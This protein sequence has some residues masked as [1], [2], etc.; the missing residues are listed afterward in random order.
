MLLEVRVL[1]IRYK[2][3]WQVTDSTG[4]MSAL[5]HETG[6]QGSENYDSPPRVRPSTK[7]H[8]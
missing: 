3:I 5:E 6:L 7:E 1:R 2:P 4:G 8:S